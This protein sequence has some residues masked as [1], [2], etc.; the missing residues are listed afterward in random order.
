[1]KTSPTSKWIIDALLT[2]GFSAAVLLDLTGLALHQWIGVGVG[3]LAA[4]H[5]VTHWDWIGAVT[6]GF[7][8]K[9]SRRARL[10]MLIDALILGGFAT[11]G[12]TGLVISTWLDLTL[13][14]YGAWASV[15]EW[16][17]YITLAALVVKLGLHRRW[18]VNVAR[19]FLAAPE[20]RPAGAASGRPAPAQAARAERGCTRREFLMLMGA[21]V[22]TLAV[23]GA[24]GKLLQ[25]LDDSS[26]AAAQSDSP[27]TATPTSSSAVANQAS[28]STTT[29]GAS[30]SGLTCAQ[31][32]GKRCSY[33]GQCRRYVDVNGNNLCDNGE[34]A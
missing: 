32:C 5:T 30:G 17:A 23:A 6:R 19:K 11:I 13:S 31:P 24:T 4:Y 9:T 1:M 20:T 3:L 21:A 10:Y 29:I 16:S 8:G 7:F 14:S 2:L 25:A 34:C 33:P 22:S 28:S 26:A 18:I 12:L 27:A 15:H